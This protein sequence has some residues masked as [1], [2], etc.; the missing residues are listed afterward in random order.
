MKNAFILLLLFVLLLSLEANDKIKVACVGNS[1]TFG[2]GVI[3]RDLNSY[4][5]Q[6]QSY[7]ED[8]Y[9]VEIFGVSGTTALFKGGYSYVN[10][11]AYKASIE[12]QPNIVLL[13]LG[14]NDSNTRHSDHIAGYKT[15]YQKIIDSYKNLSLE[16][17]LLHLSDAI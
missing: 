5:A 11:P 1:I 7:L 13:K 4:P 6:L 12:F 10:T 17:S 9:I 2:A 3:N 8:K 14:T 15:D 16:L